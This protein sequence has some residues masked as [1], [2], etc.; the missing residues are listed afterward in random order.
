V[1]VVSNVVHMSRHTVFISGLIIFICFLFDILFR[2]EMLTGCG[3][4]AAITVFFCVSTNLTITPC[5]LLKFHS[6][7]SKCQVSD[8]KR[9]RN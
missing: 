4:A 8:F 3:V 7:F 9:I 5:I 2:N 1:T 6:F